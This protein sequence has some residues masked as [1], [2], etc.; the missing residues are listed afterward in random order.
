MGF[1]TW[2]RKI[3]NSD[4]VVVVSLCLSVSDLCGMGLKGA[5]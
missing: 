1:K 3:R 4:H 5:C 2:Y